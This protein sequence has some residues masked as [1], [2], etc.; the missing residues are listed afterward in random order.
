M[1]RIFDG[2]EHLLKNDPVFSGL[3]LNPADIKRIYVGAGF[4][5]LVRIV[6]GQ[7]VST[8]A[9]D[10]LWQRLQDGIP[11][12]T[13]NSVLILKPDEMR[14]LGLS[15]QKAGYIRGLADAIN[16]GAFDPQALDPLT[17]DEVYK[18][19][20]ALKGF[21]PWSAEMF[22]MFALA[23]PDIWP[24]GDLGIQEGLRKYLG[25]EDRPDFEATQKEGERFAPHRTA[26][27]LLLWHLKE[28]D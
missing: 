21:G 24:A 16:E 19:I 25:L 8:Q 10:S 15:H 13:P 20:T 28:M 1:P 6:I 7:Q 22:L 9:A 14:N 12:V 5:G 3:G 18:A 23:R 27:A 4:R 11:N 2:L 26:A 17:D